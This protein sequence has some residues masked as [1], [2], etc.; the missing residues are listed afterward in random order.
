MESQEPQQIEDCWNSWFEAVQTRYS[1]NSRTKSVPEYMVYE[2]WHETRMGLET[3]SF[4]FYLARD[5]HK[6]ILLNIGCFQSS[7]SPIRQEVGV[8]Y[9][10]GQNPRSSIETEVGCCSD[11]PWGICNAGKKHGWLSNYGPFLGPWY[12]TAPSI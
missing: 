9:Q 8:L 3:W 2:T 12:S 10:L 5:D 7:S 6:S 4:M 1:L 11:K